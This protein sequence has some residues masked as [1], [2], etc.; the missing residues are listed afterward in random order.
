MRSVA[1]AIVGLVVTTSPGQAASPARTLD[2]AL[3]QATTIVTGTGGESQGDAFA[4]TLEA[5]LVK[6]SGNPN[7]IGDE[8]LA[9]L[10]RTAERLVVTFSYRD[11][12][13]GRPIHDE[14]GTYDRPHFLTVRFDPDRVVEA[15]AAI[16]ETVYEG[17][18]PPIQTVLQVDAI[19]DKF[20]L[21]GTTSV[22]R[23]DDMRFSLERAADQLGLT[24]RYPSTRE[25]G[26]YPLERIRELAA[27]AEDP[28]AW[29]QRESALLGHLAWDRERDIWD[30]NWTFDGSQGPVSWRVESVSFD[31][32]FRVGLR[33]TLGVLAGKPLR[34]LQ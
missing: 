17:P 22:D 6:V 10:R 7:L 3:F 18:R 1:A 11:L 31:E 25:L 14:Q 28:G 29:V 5:V 2:P 20:L 13:A 12:Y 26:S 8:R 9:G 33:G 21:T 4:L 16:G 34:P 24:I 30:C 27:G 19:R 15:L 23:A 32:A